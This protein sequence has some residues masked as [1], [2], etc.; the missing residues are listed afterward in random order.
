MKHLIF[1]SAIFLQM[2]CNLSVHAQ[3]D[4]K[5][6]DFWV[7]F[8]RNLGTQTEYQIR[9]VGGEQ[10]ATG[11]I[12]FTSL[13][14]S[15]PFFVAAGQVFTYSLNASE[16]SA[17]A[18]TSAGT[19]NSSVHIT[20][21]A[22]VTAYALNQQQASTDATNILP[23]TALGTEYY[24]MSYTVY[25]STYPD[26]FSVIATENNTGVYFNNS[27]VTTLNTGQVYCRTS[28]IDMTGSHISADK[29][30]A[31]FAMS[32]GVQIPFGQTF[33][34]ILYQ[35]LAPVNTW[36]T[37]FFV[38]VSYRSRDI[39]RIV[40][41]QNGTNITQSGGT[42]LSPTGGQTSLINLNAGQWVELMVS[43]T[44]KG[45]FISADKPVGVCTYL[46][47]Q[48]YNNSLFPGIPASSDPAQ[49][50]MPSIEQ[51][52][53]SALIAPFIPSGTTQLDAH[54]ALIITSTAT[55]NNTTIKIGA[56]ADLPL[57]GG[58]WNDHSSG[59][60]FYSMQLTATTS[61]YQF[62][63]LD[64][65]LIVMGYGTGSAESYYY[66]AS[67]AM[68]SLDAAFYVNEVHFQD[69]E[70]EDYCSSDLLTF[71]VDVQGDL[72]S[73]PGHLK[74]Y[75]DNVEQADVRDVFTWDTILPAG[76]YQIKIEALMDDNVTTK[77]E[78]A[79][80]TIDACMQ[81]V[82]DRATTPDSL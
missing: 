76:V 52:V 71:R 73:I 18:N 65:G 43:L 24:H 3:I 68:R 75:I 30:V 22:P 33:I 14:S 54:Y 59:Y 63:N 48:G 26:A 80:L 15:V 1:I 10:S 57:S 12:Y 46:A 2:F 44:N 9:I 5:G 7:T 11:N 82:D 16:K 42:L 61:A 13:N 56:G 60:S 21:S 29:P 49:A 77:T 58:T 32:N 23:I 25:S 35:Q 47:S 72:S 51:T 20:S 27:L 66:L 4:T 31:F 69:L 70:T 28:T 8:G 50:W 74:W 19:R 53:H 38:P 79:T 64:A 36:G 45:C 17:A 67:S 41:S 37:H 6:T 40:A 81:A 78:E 39:V 34:D 62:T 55:K